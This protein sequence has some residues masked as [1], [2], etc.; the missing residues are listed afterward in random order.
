MES[1]GAA[2][3][4]AVCRVA[5]IIAVVLALLAGS[6]GGAPMASAKPKIGHCVSPRGTDINELYGQPGPIV[7][8]FCLEIDGRGRWTV[9]ALWETAP[10]FGPVPAG[11]VPA[12][13]TPLDDFVAKFAG[14]R[15]VVDAFS[16]HPKSFTFTNVGDLFAEVVNGIPIANTI[17][18]GTLN[19][20]PEGE[21]TVAV[22]WTMSALHCDGIADSV[23]DNCIP[24]GESLFE[25][26]AFE[27]VR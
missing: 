17:T 22:Y 5:A 6:I 2:R 25:A 26:F 20:L 13:A 14:L 16:S 24:A 11:F 1:Y 10:E 7:V 3:W 9:T 18:L 4:R 27:V 15:Y 12:G 23:T 8:P 21:H 19:P